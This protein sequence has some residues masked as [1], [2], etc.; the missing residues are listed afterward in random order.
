LWVFIIAHIIVDFVFVRLPERD[1]FGGVRGCSNVIIV[2]GRLAG[3]AKSGVGPVN[4]LI[5]KLLS[6][7]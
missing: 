7:R 3:I 4:V 5:G 1:I 6:D 2:L